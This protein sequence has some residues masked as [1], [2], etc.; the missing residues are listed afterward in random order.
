MSERAE[1]SRRV[2]VFDTTLRDGEQSAGV[3]FRTADKVAI[4]RALAALRV[5][6]VEAGF[7]GASVAEMKAV[8]AVAREVRD[9]AVCGL[10]RA[11]ADRQRVV[12]DE[13]L[14]DICHPAAQG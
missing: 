14:H 2:A 10:A 3:S 8:D 11:R 4:A 5:D 9:V 6:V 12:P 1:E 7:P 13:D